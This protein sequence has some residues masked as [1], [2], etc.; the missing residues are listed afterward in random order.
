MRILSLLFASSS[1][2]KIVMASVLLIGL[3]ISAFSMSR[4]IVPRLGGGEKLAP[5]ERVKVLHFTLT[6]LGFSPTEMT[7]PEGLYT[8]EVINRSGLS[9]FSLHLGRLSERKLKEVD[10]ARKLGEWRGFF[11]LKRDDYVVTVNE[12]T[13]WTAR[14]Q[15]TN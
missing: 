9:M 7:V 8:I 3:A 14:L 5:P 13:E 1:R 6:P 10:S 4:W 15:V 2:R 11:N 12:K